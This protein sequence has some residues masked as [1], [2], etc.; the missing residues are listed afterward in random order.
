MTE[1]VLLSPVDE[2]NPEQP[3]RNFYI[4]P[5]GF[6]RIFAVP[7]AENGL[8][9]VRVLFEEVEGPGSKFFLYDLSEGT[10]AELV[11]DKSQIACAISDASVISNHQTSGRKF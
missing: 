5:Q 10:P 3:A 2:T 11:R 8:S 6:G 1:K 7:G 4:E 9:G